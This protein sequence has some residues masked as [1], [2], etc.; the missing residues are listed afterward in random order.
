MK[1]KLKNVYFP[2]ETKCNWVLLE[3]SICNYSK[4]PVKEEA[5]AK[6][7]AQEVGGTF[8]FSGWDN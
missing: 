4:Q 5:D 8:D 6:I 3:S 1:K 2:P 7:E